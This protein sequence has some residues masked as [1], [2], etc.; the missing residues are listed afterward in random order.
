ML[1]RDIMI[2]LYHG[3]VVDNSTS[4]AMV[5]LVGRVCD[6]SVAIMSRIEKILAYTEDICWGQVLKELCERAEDQAVKKLHLAVKGL[7]DTDWASL[8]I[9]PFEV[10]RL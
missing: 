10:L 6:Q 9:D 7:L 5:A 1:N 3:L 8:D 4:S 2:K